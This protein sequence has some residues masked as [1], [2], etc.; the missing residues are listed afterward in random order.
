MQAS[1]S[2][3]A[4]H[5]QPPPSSFPQQQQQQQQQQEDVVQ[6]NSQKALGQYGLSRTSSGQRQAD[7]SLVPW[8]KGQQDGCGFC[9]PSSALLIVRRKLPY[10]YLRVF[11]TYVKEN[12]VTIYLPTHAYTHKKCTH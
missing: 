7:G 6:R 3:Y 11:L 8:T 2:N 5:M 10:K 4:Q 1:N 12:I 9:F